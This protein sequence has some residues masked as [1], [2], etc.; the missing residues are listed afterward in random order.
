MNAYYTQFKQFY[1]AQITKML[2]TFDIELVVYDETEYFRAWNDPLFTYPFT[3]RKTKL[4]T[5]KFSIPN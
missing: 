2:N 5:L 1:R 3:P 4:T